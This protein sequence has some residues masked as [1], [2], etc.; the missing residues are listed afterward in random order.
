[1]FSCVHADIFDITDMYV[2][3]NTDIFNIVHAD[4]FD[5]IGHYRYVCHCEYRFIW[6]DGTL[7]IFIT[8]LVQIKGQWDQIQV[9]QPLVFVG[10]H[11]C[12]TTDYSPLNRSKSCWQ[13]ELWQDNDNLH[14]RL[15]YW[16]NLVFLDWSLILM[17]FR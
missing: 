17:I 15:Y 11:V 13:S 1:V 3:V 6:R 5:V 7:Q 16:T 8:Y 12:R 9:L 14:T 2:I 4:I 10:I